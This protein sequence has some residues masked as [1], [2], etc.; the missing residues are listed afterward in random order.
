[1]GR[2]AYY[3][4]GLVSYAAEGCGVAALDECVAVPSARWGRNLEFVQGAGDSSPTLRE[5]HL[6]QADINVQQ[7]MPAESPLLC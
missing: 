2:S 7:L 5:G 1:M 6:M 3:P 4:C